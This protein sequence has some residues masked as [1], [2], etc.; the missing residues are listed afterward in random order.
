[1]NTEIEARPTRPRAP[2]GPKLRARRQ[3]LGMTLDEVAAAAG[4][5]KGFLSAVERD[6][7]SPSVA[8]LLAVCDVLRLSVGALFEA[9]SDAIVRVAERRPIE[10]G[11]SGVDDQLISPASTRRFQAVLSHLDPGADGGEEL[12]SLRA[13]E[14][15][16]LV[17]HGALSIRFEGET[18]RLE[19]GDTL[20]Y[21]PRR[22]HSFANASAEAAAVALFVIMPALM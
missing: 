1:M 18:I 8:S 14:V 15:F 22:A 7:T 4:L 16:V 20:T 3:E 9:G 19:A 5:T 6:Q 21:D 10:F 13:A 17:E 12:Y 2:I 11:G